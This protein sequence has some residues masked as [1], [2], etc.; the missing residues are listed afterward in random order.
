M[1]SPNLSP[2]GVALR[3]LAGLF[4]A[5]TILYG[6]AWMYYVRFQ[7][8][9]AQLGFESRYSAPDQAAV[10]DSVEEGGPAAQAGLKAGDRITSVDGEPFDGQDSFDA[11]DHSRAG[12]IVVLTVE[13]EGMA[14]PLRLSP[15]MLDRV[16]FSLTGVLHGSL[17]Q[18]FAFYPVV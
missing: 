2:A 16:P 13:R 17:L 9:G 5:I 8:V 18:L 7:T 1:P 12:D 4:A 15:H 10:V 14:A 3:T 11:W 6:A